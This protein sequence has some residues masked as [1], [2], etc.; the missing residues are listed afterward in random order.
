MPRLNKFYTFS[1]INNLL[2][3]SLNPINL[4][5]RRKT[6]NWKEI[7]LHAISSKNVGNP[8]DFNLR[9]SAK[10]INVQKSRLPVKIAF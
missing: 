3:N 8:T 7:I 1:R 4:F 5:F 10:S 9:N 2:H 6:I